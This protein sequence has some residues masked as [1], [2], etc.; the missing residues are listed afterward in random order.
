M[1]KMV[2]RRTSGSFHHLLAALL[3]SEDTFLARCINRAVR[4]GARGSKWGEL[5]LLCPPLCRQSAC[6]SVFECVWVRL[7]VW[8]SV[9]S[10]IY[11]NSNFEFFI[12]YSFII[13]LRRVL[14]QMTRCWSKYYAL[15]PTRS[16]HACEKNTAAVR[17]FEESRCRNWAY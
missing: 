14:A 6:I 11:I 13:F 2:L 3:E 15:A 17:L 9:D 10:H 1:A 12:F 8:D 16:L 4:V 5:V 7:S